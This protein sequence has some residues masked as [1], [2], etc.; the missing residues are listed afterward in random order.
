MKTYFSKRSP[1][2]SSLTSNLSASSC[3]SVKHL[4]QKE[5]RHIVMLCTDMTT[6]TSKHII[7]AA[8]ALTYY[9]LKITM[10][11]CKYNKKLYS[12]LK[13]IQVVV[14][15]PTIPETVFGTLKNLCYLLRSAY[16]ALWTIMWCPVPFPIMII[17]ETDPIVL[18]ILYIKNFRLAYYQYCFS[19]ITRN[20]PVKST[21]LNTD[22]FTKQCISFADAILIPNNQYK[23]I[24]KRSYTNVDINPVVLYPYLSTAH[25]ENQ[26]VCSI[27]SYF[28]FMTHN[29]C[30]FLVL[31]H[32]DERSNFELAV[33]AFEHLILITQEDKK[34]NLYLIVYGHYSKNLNEERNYFKKIKQIVN[35]SRSAQQ[36]I[37]L[38]YAAVYEKLSL[39]YGCTVL[40]HTTI[41]EIFNRHILEA[42]F[43]KKAIIASRTGKVVSF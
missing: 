31:G 10:I 3:S 2:S 27:Y 28:P 13:K 24:F 9:D 43:M 14:L 15:N 16:A 5:D 38:E 19:A 25:V 18:P 22:Y 42:M 12:H 36:F 39:I 37:L 4:K 1:I 7:D 23:S 33:R 35:S 41:D 30:I 32:Y 20:T 6:K 34:K 29:S 26:E 17:C 8:I 21:V 40:L 11:T